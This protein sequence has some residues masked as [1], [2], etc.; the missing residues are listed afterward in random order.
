MKDIKETLAELAGVR[1]A[2]KTACASMTYNA[3]LREWTAAKIDERCDSILAH[4]TTLEAENARLKA[5]RLE[6]HDRVLKWQR[7]CNK[8][9]QERDILAADAA[10]MRKALTDATANLAGAASAYRKHAGRAKH[11]HPKSVADAL[12]T[13]RADDFDK[14]TE[15][16]RAALLPSDAEKNDA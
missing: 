7:E 3:E 13:T 10:R 8:V 4:I 15:R 14:A 2:L 5:D 6:A 1:A 12:F 16:A 11:L 9:G